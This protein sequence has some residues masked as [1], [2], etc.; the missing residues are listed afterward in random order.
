MRRSLLGACE[1]APGDPRRRGDSV[2]PTRSRA[3]ARGGN[4]DLR[5]A[6][7]GAASRHG[8]LPPRRRP[9]AAG[10]PSHLT[11]CRCVRR[12]AGEGAQ[13][14]A[15]A[16]ALLDLYTPER[17]EVSVGEAALMLGLAKST[18]HRLLAT[19]RDCGYLRQ[20][21]RSGRYA[22]GAK[23]LMLARAYDADHGFPRLARPVMER[24]RDEVNETVG[25]YVCEGD[26]RYCIERLE[27]SHDMRLVVNVGQR[28]PLDR[29]A[30]GRILS[31]TPAQAQRAGAVITR[32]ERVPN[33]CGVA[34]GIFD[35]NAH[36]VAALDVT[37]PLDR[38]GDGRAERYAALVVSAA[39]EIS[40]A[41]GH[42][43]IER[44]P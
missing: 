6:W 35:A 27:S 14:V 37:G 16:A 36:L 26:A 15:R 19:L 21:Q 12:S 20:D 24:L 41:L 23:V 8:R 7:G 11:E 17:R 40:A 30:A 34:A 10:L 44:T 31:M 22:L 38:F 39:A 13:T 42:R 32:A 9:A 43:P 1:R 4:L 5:S 28:M 33:A 18:A 3:R 2:R 25:L 29:G